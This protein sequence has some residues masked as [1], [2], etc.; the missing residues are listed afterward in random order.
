MRKFR[1][2]HPARGRSRPAFTLIELL[3]VIAIIAILAAMLL[4]SLA[5]AK[6]KAAAVSCLNNTRQL[7]VAWQMYAH[8]NN[9][10][11]V[12]ALHGSEARNGTGDP[13]YGVGWVEGW[14]DW[15]TGSDNTNLDFLIN[16]KFAKLAQ[17]VSK[18]KNVF[19]C[20]A[21]VFLSA[22]QRT[23]GWSARSRSLAGNVGVGPGNAETAGSWDAI[24][25]HYIKTSEFLYPGAAETW[26]FND[27]HPDS[28]NDAAF[29]NPNQFQVRDVPAAYHCGAAGFSFADGHSET[30]K[31]RGCLAQ[32]RVRQVV[33]VDGQYINGT[34]SSTVPNDPDI[35][36]LSYH[37]GRVGPASY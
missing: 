24:Y 19:K 35:H 9:D 30:H 25:K 34:I 5:R 12:P 13:V 14:L 17:Y 20:P 32:P 33:A 10:R 2:T 11:I 3:V 18:S 36:W 6:C 26:V 27:E 15:T 16:D 28:I 29:F 1:S 8:D 23:A 21:D 37:G 4:P 7:M 31:W 22:P